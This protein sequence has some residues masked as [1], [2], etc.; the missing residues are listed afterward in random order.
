MGDGSSVCIQCK[1]TIQTP[2]AGQRRRYCSTKCYEEAP[3]RQRRLAK[4]PKTKGKRFGMLVCEEY[5][6]NK[7]WLCRCDCGNTVVRSTQWLLSRKL[8]LNCG[9]VL[10]EHPKP[11]HYNDLTGLVINCWTVVGRNGIDNTGATLWNVRCSNGHEFSK[12]PQDLKKRAKFCVKCK[13]GRGK[14]ARGSAPKEVG[15]D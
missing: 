13:I 5:K 4:E 14:A 7:E 10:Y 15:S 2:L 8:V 11:S 3:K 12:R 1:A 6:G 9:C